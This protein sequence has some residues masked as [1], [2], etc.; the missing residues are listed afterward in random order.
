MRLKRPKK[1]NRGQWEAL[2]ETTQKSILYDDLLERLQKVETELKDLSKYCA[3]TE[4]CLVKSERRLK[5][6]V[7][8]LSESK[9]LMNPAI[10]LVDDIDDFIEEQSTS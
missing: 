9:L 10:S 3:H 1:F 4:D 2:T 5:E 8:L 6:A 7:Q